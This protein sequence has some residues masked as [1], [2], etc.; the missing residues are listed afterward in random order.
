MR[1]TDR[2]RGESKE[3][4]KDQQVRREVLDEIGPLCGPKREFCT[5]CVRP[6]SGPSRAKRGNRYWQPV[7][8]L[9]GDIKGRSPLTGS[10][11]V[12]DNSATHYRNPNRDQAR[13]DWDRSRRRTDAGSSRDDRRPGDDGL[14]P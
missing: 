1:V 10:E 2:R 4:R 6:H 13:G 3:L 7:K 9:G 5:R 11:I 8:G 14:K 12:Q